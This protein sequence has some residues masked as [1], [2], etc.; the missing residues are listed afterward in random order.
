MATRTLG[1]III[2]YPDSKEGEKFADFLEEEIEKELEED[3]GGIMDEYRDKGMS[4]GDFFR[5]E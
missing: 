5:Q 3:E 4:P 1:K 2:D